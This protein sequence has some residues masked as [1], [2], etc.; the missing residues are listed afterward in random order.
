MLPQKVWFGAQKC[1]CTCHQRQYKHDGNKECC[2]VCDYC[3]IR[4]IAEHYTLHR[5][6]HEAHEKLGDKK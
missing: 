6:C 1:D 5:M 2:I 4:I 3:K